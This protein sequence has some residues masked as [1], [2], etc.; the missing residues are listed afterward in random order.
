MYDNPNKPDSRRIPAF[1]VLQDT[2]EI[3][4]VCKKKLG[5][6]LWDIVSLR[7][8]DTDYQAPSPD[9]PT[10]LTRNFCVVTDREQIRPRNQKTQARYCFW[11]FSPLIMLFSHLFHENREGIANIKEHRA[12]I[13]P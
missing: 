7:M 4:D 1:N 9:R 13:Q 5:I 6:I 11:L 2:P 12:N 3:M 8:P 10:S